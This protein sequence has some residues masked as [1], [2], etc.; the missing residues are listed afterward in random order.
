MLQALASVGRLLGLA[1]P[2]LADD[3]E[4]RAWGRVRCDTELTCRP[5]AGGAAPL[6][7]RARDISP[8]GISLTLGRAF[9]PGELLSITL[10]GGGPGQTEE[11]LGCVVRCGELDG[12]F[13][14]ACTFAAHLDDA[15]LQRFGARRQRAEPT[16]Q[17]SWAR[18]ACQ[19]RAAFQVVRGG[20]ASAT[21][22]AAVLNISASGVALQVPLALHVG[23]LLSVELRRDDQ[24]VLV[25]LASVVRVATELAGERLVGCN[26]IRE[27]PEETIAALL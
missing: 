2:Q 13:A 11:V 15:D 9:Q 25:T 10:P 12:A 21:W 19:A 18:F 4:R 24:P 7:A 17:R 14:V 27:L 8:G 20:E 3:E 23:D 26:F 22:Q 5:T 6:P 16:D 1:G